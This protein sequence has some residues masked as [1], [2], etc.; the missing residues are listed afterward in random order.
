MA[1]HSILKEGQS[2]TFS[3]YFELTVDPEELLA[4]VE[5]DGLRQAQ[6]DRPIL[7]LND[8]RQHKS[9][10]TLFFQPW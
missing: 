6:N 2:H 7:S 8:H 3:Q 4:E 5:H 10:W 1:R 9:T